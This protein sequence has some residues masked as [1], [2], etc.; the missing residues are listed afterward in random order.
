MHMVIRAIVYAKTEDEALKK[1]RKIFEQLC[2]TE[3]DYFTL[4]NDDTSTVSGKARWGELPVVAKA[5]SKEGK[6]LIAEGMEATK[7]EFLDSVAKIKNS[8]E[9]YSAEELFE[10]EGFSEEDLDKFG[11]DFRHNCYR[12][13]MYRG[14]LIWLYDDDGE[15][16]RTPKHLKRVLEKWKSIYEDK[17]KENPYKDLDIWVVPADVHF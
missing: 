5:D 4:F 11:I 7:R 9:K 14:Y 17:G 2:E 15:G 13:G 6:R 10:M 3:F 16:I 8:L 1:A 12:A